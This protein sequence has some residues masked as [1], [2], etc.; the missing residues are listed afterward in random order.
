MGGGGGSGSEN[1]AVRA[2]TGVHRNQGCDF[3]AC[4]WFFTAVT[5]SSVKFSPNSFLMAGRQ[6]VEM[7]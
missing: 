7:K 1:T 2:A 3:P 5:S 6:G 4:F